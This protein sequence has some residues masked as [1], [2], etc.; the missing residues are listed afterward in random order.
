MD[1]DGSVFFG[2]EIEGLQRRLSLWKSRAALG[3]V[4][5]PGVLIMGSEEGD[6]AVWNGSGDMHRDKVLTGT[7]DPAV[8]LQHTIR[9]SSDSE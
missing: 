6:R 9:A 3:T 5:D 2:D 1:T 7:G 8:S 4:E